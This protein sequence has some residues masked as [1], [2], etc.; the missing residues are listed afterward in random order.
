MKEIKLN[1]TLISLITAILLLASP[2][3]PRA[4]IIQLENTYT[5]SG[6]W[7]MQSNPFWQSFTVSSG[8]LTTFALAV[9]SS[10]TATYGTVD[11][12]AGE[13]TG[14]ALLKSVTALRI[15]KPWLNG[16][17]RFW[18][19]DFGGISLAAGTYTAYYHD[20]MY[21]AVTP[22]WV[23]GMW[24]KSAYSGGTLATN[25]TV[26]TPYDLAFYTQSPTGVG[27]Y[28]APSGGGGG[29]GGAVATPEPGT[30]MLL[31]SGVLTFGLS[32]FRRRKRE[33]SA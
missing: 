19:A 22:G 9:T 14:G 4:D 20:N 32:R 33:V 15:A 10:N 17:D 11:L 18:V 13:G 7:N 23:V 30:M 8:E 28:V 5:G 2:S 31:G 24:T 1:R 21:D 29:G 12:Y 25:G 16:V 6:S 26:Q 3:A 27:S